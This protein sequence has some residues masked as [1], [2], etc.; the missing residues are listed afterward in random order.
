MNNTT[1]TAETDERRKVVMT[2]YAATQLVNNAL[3]RAGVIDPRTG[4]PKA[5][6]S[7]M[8]YIYADR[9]KFAVT[10]AADGRWNVDRESFGTWV[11]S[12]VEAAVERQERRREI[13]A[14]MRTR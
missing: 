3:R 9:G 1:G 11:D 8:L 5:I 4:Q 12:Y 10:R 14:E 2:P 6:G 7:P 13:D